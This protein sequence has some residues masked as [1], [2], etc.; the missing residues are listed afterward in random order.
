LVARWAGRDIELR[1][2]RC[3]RVV[4]IVIEADGQLRIREEV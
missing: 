3:K 1:C 4:L 2:Q